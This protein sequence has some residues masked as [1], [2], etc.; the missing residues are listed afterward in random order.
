MA[1]GLGSDFDGTQVP[2]E[3]GSAAGLQN[4]VRTMR[5]RQFGEK[6]IEK[7]CYRNWLSLLGRTW[8]PGR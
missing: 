8:G 2:A 4:L 5:E 1:L 6:L 3:L 7:I